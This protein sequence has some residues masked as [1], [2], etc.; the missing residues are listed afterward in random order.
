MDFDH[1]LRVFRL[2]CYHLKQDPGYAA[3]ML[4]TDTE[5]R[6]VAELEKLVLEYSEVIAGKSGPVLTR[7]A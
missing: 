3:G 5:K 4:L 1:A 6:A 7:G 2:Y